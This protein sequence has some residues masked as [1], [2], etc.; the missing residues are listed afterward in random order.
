[1]LW[2]EVS[3]VHSRLKG[4]TMRYIGFNGYEVWCGMRHHVCTAD[5]H[6]LLP[7]GYCRELEQLRN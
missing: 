4:A 7:G 5:G 2:Y 1:M 3:R 6:A